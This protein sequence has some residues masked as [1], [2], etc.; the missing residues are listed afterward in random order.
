M[1]KLSIFLA[2]LLLSFCGIAQLKTT[3][4][5][6]ENF[7]GNNNG[8]P[9]EYHEIIIDTISNP[10]NIWQIG[11]ATKRTFQSTNNVIVTD[12]INDYKKNDTSSF[13]IKQ[14]AAWL[15]YTTPVFFSLRGKYATHMD[16]PGSD[17]GMMHLS[18][19]NGQT[20]RR[21][22]DTI[23]NINMSSNA[24]VLKGNSNGWKYF[25]LDF[26]SY[27]MADSLQRGDTI[28][29]KI[30][31][32]SDGIGNNKDGLM[33]DDFQMDDYFESSVSDINSS[34][35]L[36]ISPNP[37]SS[38]IFNISYPYNFVQGTITIFDVFG[39][40]L[41]QT[42]LQKQ[43]DLQ[44]LPAGMYFYKASFKGFE[45]EYSGRLIKQ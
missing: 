8:W 19:N 41:K 17:F 35:P 10:T 37:S 13:I 42:T 45:N 28:L 27:A 15:D 40:K 36:S 38:G 31:F 34:N 12:T 2:L 30:T 21:I 7:D 1:K 14:V 24:P 26:F 4:T 23:S 9:N 3:S 16:G 39:R 5:F 22:D 18:L 43:I 29:I 25:F 32:I 44:E 33:F 6:Y 20:W 11:K